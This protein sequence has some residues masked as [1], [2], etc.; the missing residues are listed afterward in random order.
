MERW[1]GQGRRAG[2]PVRATQQ[3]GPRNAPCR[4]AQWLLTLK[5]AMASA[6]V[7]HPMRI[8]L[9]FHPT[10]MACHLSCSPLPTLLHPHPSPGSPPATPQP[11]QLQTYKMQG[12][13][14]WPTLTHR[15]VLDAS[16]SSCAPARPRPDSQ[17]QS[18]LLDTGP[19][20]DPAATGVHTDSR[21]PAAVPG[22]G[23]SPV[24]SL[25]STT[26]PACR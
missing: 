2:G 7:T 22:P 5:K 26:G 24:L 25:A 18:P 8:L 3:G 23:L 20:G 21:R 9:G 4:G 17:H 19:G 15:C 6:V 12:H 14:P 16:R 13:G 11:L 10:G 1:S